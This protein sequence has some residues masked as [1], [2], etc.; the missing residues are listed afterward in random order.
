MKHFIDGSKHILICAM[1]VVILTVFMLGIKYLFSV[2]D[3]WSLGCIYGITGIQLIQFGA[4]LMF[5]K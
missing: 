3:E 2:D 4:T 1:S 5:K